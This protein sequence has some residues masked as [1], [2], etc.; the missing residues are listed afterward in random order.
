MRTSGPNY[1]HVLVESEEGIAG[2]VKVDRYTVH[3]D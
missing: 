1:I 3:H 2:Q